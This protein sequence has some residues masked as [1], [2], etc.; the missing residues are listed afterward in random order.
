MH[1]DIN[2]QLAQCFPETAE[3]WGRCGKKVAYPSA[4]AACAVKQRREA[5]VTGLTLTIYPCE[6]GNHW[7]LSSMASS[8]AQMA[9]IQASGTEWLH[10][11]RAEMERYPTG[12]AT[13]ERQLGAMMREINRGYQP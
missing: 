1:E 3:R 12:R 9:R 2:R 7:H 5:Q 4:A 6:D 8:P 11:M 13:L 10:G